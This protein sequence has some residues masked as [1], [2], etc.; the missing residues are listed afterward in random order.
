[1]LR[2]TVD[3]GIM[4]A[5]SIDHTDALHV[6]ASGLAFHGCFPADSANDSILFQLPRL[7]C[8]VQSASCFVDSPY[9]RQ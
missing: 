6:E 2:N 1:M 4:T 8:T 9:G 7:A 5:F 3:I